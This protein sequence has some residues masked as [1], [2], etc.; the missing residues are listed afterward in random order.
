MSNKQSERGAKADRG[1]L[2][3]HRR[4]ILVGGAIIGAA[5]TLNAGT[6][7]RVAQAQQSVPPIP[8]SPNWARAMPTGPVAGTR[9]TEPYARMVMRDAFFWAWPMINIYNKR[10]AFAQLPEAG[11]IGGVLPAAPLNRLS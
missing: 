9:I 7:K 3:P 1:G 5:S 8:P 10:L 4:N 11:R 2:A 6:L